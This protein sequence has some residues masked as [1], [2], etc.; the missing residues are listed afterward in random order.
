M[1][2]AWSWAGAAVI[3]LLLAARAPAQETEEQYVAERDPLV[4]KKLSEWQDRK[5][6]LMMTWAP[7]S[8]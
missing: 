1:R 3:G 2:R 5:F 6:G 8:Q 4:L 7:S